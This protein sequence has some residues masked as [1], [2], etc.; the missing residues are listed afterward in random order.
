M[1]RRDFT[2][3]KKKY[4]FVEDMTRSHDMPDPHYHNYY[5][6]YFLIYGKCNFSV[7]NHIYQLKKNEMLIIPPGMIHCGFEYLEKS[8]RI[9]INFS[10]NSIGD[11]F[12]KQLSQFRT[13]SFYIPPNATYVYELMTKLLDEYNGIDSLSEK[14]KFCQ[15]HLLL[16]YVIRSR[17]RFQHAPQNRLIETTE[18]FMKYVADNYSEDISVSNLSKE[19]GYSANYISKIFKEVSG[20]GFNQYLTLHRI[21]NAEYL[22]STT[23]KSISEIAASC[24]FNDSN[25]FS[26]A[27]KK[28]HGISPSKY[29]NMRQGVQK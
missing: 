26:T 23:S 27:F 2:L 5:E 10:K 16:E 22:L 12:A 8:R 18:G 15:L 28:T 25:Y 20:I 21:K 1:L 6:I 14:M 11:E 3:D 24:G 7:E 9:V 29:R 19:F 4:L 17:A 13:D